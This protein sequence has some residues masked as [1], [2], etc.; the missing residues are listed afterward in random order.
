MPEREHTTPAT[1]PSLKIKTAN[2]IK[3]N[4]IDRVSSQIL[5]A[6]IGVILA[7]VL[8]QEDFGLVGVLLIFQAFATLFVDS[9]FG[10][11]LLQK[12]N[13]T[14]TD[15]STVF[16]FNVILSIAVYAILWLCAPAIASLFHDNRLIPLSKGM[17][18]TFVFNA[19]GIVQ[20][21]RLMKLMDVRQIAIANIAG[22]TLSGI[23]GIYLA[24]SGYGA[25][26]LVWQSVT[27]AAV[28][29]GW[30]WL[31]CGWM[32]SA[33]ISKQS[34]S[35]IW[36]IGLSVF[37][38]SFLNT[39]C[40]NIYSF[41]IGAY[42]RPLSALG[43]YTQAD[44]WSKMG[45]ASL[46][47][48]MTASFI[49]LLSKAG[50]DRP[51]F[52]RYLKKINRFSSFIT[53]PALIGLAVIGT[54]LFHTLFSDKWDAAIPLFQILAIRGIFVVYLSLYNNVLLALGKGALIVKIEIIKDAIL[55]ISILATVFCHSILLLVWGQ[56]AASFIT[57]LTVL[58]ITARASGYSAG[59]MIGDTL[60]FM[61]PTIAMA[62][63]CR[64]ISSL[65]ASPLVILC[66]QISGGIA[67]Y[68]IILI[69][70]RTPELKEAATYFT[71]RMR[72]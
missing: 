54:P 38:S 15:Y 29:S 43:V 45:S 71:G 62:I 25:W 36:R 21:N 58:F 37:S 5:Y 3:W 27:L 16:W 42:F 1:H 40:L 32:P 20:T 46:S 30:L 65:I 51:R 8:P 2:T 22:L 14:Q 31:R 48:V 47:Q 11:A 55:V 10:A 24:L 56:L 17:F 49:P 66:A 28:K 23:I 53:L 67:V 44:K 68:V 34:F 60:P 70:T 6:A 69:L 9:G 19:L 61:L 39:V 50:D 64:A 13:P 4:S 59:M 63:T 41:I 18:L 26:A 33:V 72:Q 35:E 57:W 12:K 52:H 7:N